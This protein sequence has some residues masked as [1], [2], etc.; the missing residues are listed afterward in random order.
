M[1]PAEG[2][3]DNSEASMWRTKQVIFVMAIFEF[4][5]VFVGFD[6]GVFDCW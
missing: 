1:I 3:W 6:Y 4:V 2:I 5:W